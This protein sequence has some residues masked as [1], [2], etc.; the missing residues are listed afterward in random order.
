VLCCRG[1]GGKVVFGFYGTVKLYLS[2]CHVAFSLCGEGFD[3]MESYL[4][5]EVFHPGSFATSRIVDWVMFTSL[6]VD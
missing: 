3:E 6:W 5:R 1:W 4:R 2:Q